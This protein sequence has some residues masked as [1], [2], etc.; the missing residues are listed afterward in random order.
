M[1]GSEHKMQKPLFQTFAEHVTELLKIL[2]LSQDYFQLSTTRTSA[3]LTLLIKK[4]SQQS[5]C[6]I[7]RLESAP[8]TSFS[9]KPFIE[10]SIWIVTR[11]CED[12]LK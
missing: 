12:H 11:S 3:A 6:N 7:R 9:V 5:F 4:G 2:K 1:F 10:D 8:K